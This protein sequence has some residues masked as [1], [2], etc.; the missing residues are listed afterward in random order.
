MNQ[1]GLQLRGAKYL[2]EKL[3]W[4]LKD[5]RGATVFAQDGAEYFLQVLHSQ[6]DQPPLLQAILTHN[7]ICAKAFPNNTVLSQTCA[8]FL[9]FNKRLNKG[10]WR[11]GT[12]QLGAA[13]AWPAEWPRSIAACVQAVCK[14][15]L[16]QKAECMACGCLQQVFIT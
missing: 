9:P 15:Q 7:W 13:C 5:P 12:I 8:I 4:R 2:W 6:R 14:H 1:T 10:Q 3:V 11:E 16:A